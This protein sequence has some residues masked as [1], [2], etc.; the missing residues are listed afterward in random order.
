[1]MGNWKGGFFSMRALN[2][3]VAVL[4][5]LSLLGGANVGCSSF[6]MG[7]ADRNALKSGSLVES[8]PLGVPWTRIAMLAAD[9]DRPNEI[10]LDF[11]TSFPA[12]VEELRRRV[13]DQGH[14]YGPNQ[15][16]GVG[17]DGGEHNGP[18]DHGLRLFTLAQP[19]DTQTTD[20]AGGARLLIVI[21]GDSARHND[22]RRRIGER[23]EHLQ[24]AG[25]PK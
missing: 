16:R 22:M 19:F 20:I 18:R 5:S 25:C 1:M 2:E 23:V 21:S 14:A 9:A 8:C 10:A 13:R 24:S 4:L 11:T 17:H 7:A 3:T 6:A 12:N 15:H